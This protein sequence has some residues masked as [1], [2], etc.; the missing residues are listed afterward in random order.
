MLKP[1][2]VIALFIGIASATTYFG[3]PNNTQVQ[4]NTAGTTYILNSTCSVTTATAIQIGADNVTL[5][6]AGNEII[7]N[8]IVG[9]YGVFS[10]SKNNITIKNCVIRYYQYGVFLSTVSRSLINNTYADGYY[11]AAPC[12]ENMDEY[13][14]NAEQGC[15]GSYTEGYCEGEGSGGGDNPCWGLSGRQC[16]RMGEECA[17]YNAGDC[18]G[19]CSVNKDPCSKIS[20]E[21][22]CLETDTEFGVCDY[23]RECSVCHLASSAVVCADL[24]SQE[25]CEA[26]SCTWVEGTFSC[27]G[28]PTCSTLGTCAA[29]RINFGAN[30]T[31]QNTSAEGAMGLYTQYSHNL[32][33]T[34]ANYANEKYGIL[35]Q[36]ANRST[37]SNQYLNISN[38]MGIAASYG[39]DLTI[40]KSRINLT[41][42]S[43]AI[44]TQITPRTIVTNTNITSVGSG[45]N[46]ENSNGSVAENLSIATTTSYGLYTYQA[47]NCSIKNI[48]STATTGY[49]IYFQGAGCIIDNITATT[50]QNDAHPITLQTAHYNNISNINATGY[51][52]SFTVLSMVSSSN[53]NITNFI[54][55]APATTQ[56]YA[57][58][59]YQANNN[60]FRNITFY[61]FYNEGIDLYQSSNNL[62]SGGSVRGRHNTYGTIDIHGG[63]AYQTLNNTFENLYIDGG[64]ATKAIYIE[65]YSYNNTFR[66][67]TI[68]NASSK[69]YIFGVA[70]SATF[71]LNNFTDV[72]MNYP[73]YYLYAASSYAPN[74]TCMYDGKLQGNIYPNAVNLTGTTTSSIPGYNIGTGGGQYPYN[75]TTSGGMFSCGL[76]T[77]VD[78][79]PLF[80]SVPATGCTPPA[81]GNWSFACGCNVSNAAISINFLLY[82][83]TGTSNFRNVT[84]TY[85]GMRA[86]AEG[87]FCIF[88]WQNGTIHRVG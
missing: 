63:G 42:G 22:E 79:A 21:K 70:S 15:S 47:T 81:S 36:G 86:T 14:C 62:F 1:I 73:A 78:N 56:G 68:T 71:C 77:C 25:E 18:G 26:V 13:T 29:F 85:K 5:D 9:T 16:E 64:G 41:S 82:N 34:T 48:V 3:C 58:Y 46:I 65:N 17:W 54:A 19:F 67:N 87:T 11:Y 60:T 80:Y 49:P 74:M 27:S 39:N 23:D 7:G 83:G 45:L 72:V 69:V 84:L 53:N 10:D 55:N 44:I 24:P 50:T 52:N 33:S 37:F 38:G 66:N 8:N 76:T 75:T 43:Y 20:D 51:S 30:N 31:M 35:I 12:N 6:C 61:S 57:M 32:T 59:A 40:D 28:D 4:L 88:N 2:L